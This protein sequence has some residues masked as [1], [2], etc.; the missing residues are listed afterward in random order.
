M[1]VNE[2]LLIV[3]SRQVNFDRDQKAAAIDC[4]NPIDYLATSVI[5]TDPFGYGQYNLTHELITFT[6]KYMADIA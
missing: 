3:L 4:Q 6:A 2:E 5:E 1:L